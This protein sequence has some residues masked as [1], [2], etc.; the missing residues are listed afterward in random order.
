MTPSPREILDTIKA[1]GIN[2]EVMAR[3]G[4]NISTL[5]AYATR[6]QD[7]LQPRHREAIARWL[8]LHAD[9]SAAFAD[10]LTSAN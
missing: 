5:R 4:I 8:R 2:A 6:Q 10:D 1:L 9:L 7:Y 3:D